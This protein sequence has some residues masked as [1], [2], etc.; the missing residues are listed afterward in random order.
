[1][2]ETLLAALQSDTPIDDNALRGWLMGILKHKL[3]D[4]FR[5][6]AVRRAE[7]LADEPAAPFSAD[8][9]WNRPPARW[10]EDPA[11][12][13]EIDELRHQVADCQAKLPAPLLAAYVLREVDGHEIE[14]ACHLLNISANHLAVRL[15]RARLLLR[16]CVERYL[17]ANRP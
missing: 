16:E 5:R 9:L 17:K 15:Y 8:G 13:L 7:S 4:H 3:I 12:R 14:S 2:Q 1:V 10:N 11:R 6:S